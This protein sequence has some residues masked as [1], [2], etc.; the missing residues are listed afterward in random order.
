MGISERR[1]REREKRRGEILDAAWEVARETGWAGFSVERVAARA[2]LGR[3]TVYGYFESLEALVA[4]MAGQALSDLSGRT[5]AAEGL[6]EALDVPVRFAQSSPAAF[7][8]LFPQSVDPRAAF[9]NDKLQD[10]RKEAQQLVGRLKRLASRSGATLPDDAQSAAAFLAGIS[11]A[12]AVV[13]ELRASTTL[14]RRFQD[15]CLGGGD[16]RT[17][18]NDEPERSVDP[19]GG[20]GKER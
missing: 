19:D 2:E 13:P 7:G 18:G 16:A 8:L 20:V 11:M 17:T 14:R 1:A 10:I 4:Q 15:F 5:A 9:S 6:A 3:A 12:A